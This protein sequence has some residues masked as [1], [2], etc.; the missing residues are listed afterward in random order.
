MQHCICGVTESNSHFLLSCARYNLIRQ[1]MLNS[2]QLNIPQNVHI[3]THLLLSGDNDNLSVEENTLSFAEV[4]KYIRKTKRFSPWQTYT[5]RV[6]TVLIKRSSAVTS[7]DLT[8]LYITWLDVYS[9]LS[10]SFSS[11]SLPLSLSPNIFVI[12]ALYNMYFVQI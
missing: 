2:I 3:N 12:F 6:L 11:L 10:L 8:E 4:Q 9:T 5:H 7:Y 1:D